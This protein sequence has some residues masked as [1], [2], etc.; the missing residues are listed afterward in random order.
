M[1]KHLPAILSD[2]LEIKT[3][4]RVII[5][6]VAHLLEMKASDR[7]DELDIH[8]LRHITMGNIV[9]YFYSREDESLSR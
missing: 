5:C 7:S 3:W 1:N 4:S 6:V 2:R 9:I 8:V